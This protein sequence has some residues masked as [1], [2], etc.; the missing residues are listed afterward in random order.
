MTKPVVLIYASK[1]TPRLSY[2]LQFLFKR[3]ATIEFETTTN[4]E[5]FE[6]RSNL[7][8]INYS[9]LSSEKAITISPVK[10]LFQSAI[11][12][13]EPTTFVTSA[14]TTRWFKT[15][16]G[17]FEYDVLAFI[18]YNLVRYEEYLPY[19]ADYFGRF[20]AN[21]SIQVKS[22][23]WVDPIADQ[24]AFE[25]IYLLQEKFN[26]TLPLKSYAPKITVDVDAAYLYKHK[27]VVRS[28]MGY[29][30]DLV[31]LNSKAIKQR[32]KTQLGIAN[33][34]FDTFQKFIEIHKSAK[35]QALFLFLMG[36]YGEHDRPIDSN[37]KTFQSLIKH[38]ND[39]FKIGLHASFK[40]NSTQ[41]LV[42]EEILRLTEIAHTEIN[43][44]RQ[45]LNWLRFPETYRNLNEAEILFDYSMG[46][47]NLN[48]FRN[49]SARPIPFYDLEQN[50]TLEIEIHPYCISD[51]VMNY[52]Q[53][54]TPEQ[55][56]EE[57]NLYLEKVKNVHGQFVVNW[58]NEALSEF[59][60]WFGWTQVYEHLVHQLAQWND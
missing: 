44:N 33:D 48:G 18:F 54:Y 12:N 38:V 41:G 10:L 9:D 21:Q 58:H 3:V 25:L 32:A 20:D 24:A 28:V 14:Q 39:Y 30:K 7:L 43:S 59:K 4:F 19:Q 31:E 27:G 13:I 8:K 37:Q 50:T 16:K 52:F 40:S 36:N 34:P 23:I 5:D 22:G 49:G 51:S 55:A 57:I 15:N 17:E 2:V 47:S 29:L 60:E 53:S 26:T 45:H 6:Q 56:I 1:V 46:F 11:E 35:V 42:Q